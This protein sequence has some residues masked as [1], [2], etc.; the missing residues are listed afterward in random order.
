MLN[1]KTF[2]QNA[3]AF[4]NSGNETGSD[5]RLNLPE[6]DVELPTTTTKEPVRIYRVRKTGKTYEI[7]A[8]NNVSW[9]CPA[10]HYVRL[11]MAGKA[12]QV[13]DKVMLEF[14][15]NGVVKSFRIVSKRTP[16]LA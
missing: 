15:R 3:A 7:N 9:Y 4:I 16:G 8:E 2:I 14:Y 13:G 6:M 12:P 1:F 10:P 5:G 11:L